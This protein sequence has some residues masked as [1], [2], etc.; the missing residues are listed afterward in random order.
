MADLPRTWAFALY[1]IGF[2]LC[3]YGRHLTRVAAFFLC[4]SMQVVCSLLSR[5][6][7]SNIS[8]PIRRI[9]RPLLLPSGGEQ[10]GAL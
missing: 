10:R 9:V 5:H 2:L 8:M 7:E 1:S 6:E 4:L 3:F